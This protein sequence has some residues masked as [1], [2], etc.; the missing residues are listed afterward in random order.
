M[1]YQV[2]S[3]ASDTYLPAYYDVGTLR[4][5]AMVKRALQAD[6]GL[7][8][9]PDAL[10]FGVVSRLTEQKGLHLLPQVLAELVQRGGQLALQGQGDAGLEQIFV[11]AANRYPA[12]VRVR[13]GYDEGTAHSIIAGSDVIVMPSAFEPCGLTQLYGLR[14]GTLPMVRHVGGL[15]DTVVDCTPDN[16]A[17]GSATGFVF[18]DLGASALSQAVRRAFALARHGDQWAAVQARAMTLRFDW[19][20]AARHYLAAYRSL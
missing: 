5:K 14:Y 3:P 15:A 16:L 1:D 18:D 9:R 12:Q 20:S 17:N 10:I 8:Q 6:F 13:I 19:P 11:D 7:E 4:N 2:W